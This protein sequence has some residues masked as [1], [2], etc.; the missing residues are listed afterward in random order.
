MGWLRKQRDLL[1]LLVVWAILLQSIALPFTT[2]LHAATLSSEPGQASILCTSRGTVVTPESPGHTNK[3]SDCQCCQMSCRPGCGGA[4]DGI[5]PNF[6]RVPL[7][8]STVIAVIT[9]GLDAPTATPAGHAAAQPRAPP[10][11]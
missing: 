11:A 2:G 8:S 10:H 9:P 1:G 3:G 4:C 7:P 5:L 6:A